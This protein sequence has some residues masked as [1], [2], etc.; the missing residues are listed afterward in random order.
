VTADG[1]E[2]DDTST[3][4]PVAASVHEALKVGSKSI[5]VTK[6]Q[7]CLASKTQSPSKLRWRLSVTVRRTCRFEITLKSIAPLGLVDSRRYREA[8]WLI[9]A[10]NPATLAKV[11]VYIIVSI[12]EFT[13]CRVTIRF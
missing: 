4:P 8:V 3:P 13:I 2:P 5:M 10:K 12:H 11:Q 6:P 9:S 7:V 1:R